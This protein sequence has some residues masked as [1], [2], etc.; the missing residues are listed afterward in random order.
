MP[1]TKAGKSYDHAG[2]LYFANAAPG[3]MSRGTTPD[4]VIY[5]Q[6]EDPDAY[7]GNRGFDNPGGTP[8]G[9]I[10]VGDLI[11]HLRIVVDKPVYRAALQRLRDATDDQ[12]LSPRLP[13]G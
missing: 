5:D 8:K 6:V 7:N 4:V 13:K 11:E 9:Y 2:T 1:W 10:T 3:R 12:S